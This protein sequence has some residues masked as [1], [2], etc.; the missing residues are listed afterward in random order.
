MT[1]G[2]R[3]GRKVPRTYLPDGLLT[4]L[5][6]KAMN[7]LAQGLSHSE[8]GKLMQCTPANVSHLATAAVRKLDCKNVNH[9]LVRMAREGMLTFP[10]PN[11]HMSDNDLATHTYVQK[12]LS[13]SIGDDAAHVLMERWMQYATH[14]VLDEI[15]WEREW[16][17][18]YRLIPGLR[19]A[20]ELIR[21]MGWV[22][23]D[24]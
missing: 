6:Y 17:G 10:V 11:Q 23:C 3:E 7:Y 4:D 1:S 19:R 16:V 18:D 24:D 12:L 9:A 5:Q 14:H 13:R 21:G 2:D 22:G 8:I 15:Q 20:Y